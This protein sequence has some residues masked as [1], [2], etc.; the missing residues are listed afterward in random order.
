MLRWND[1]GKRDVN[2]INRRKSN[3]IVDGKIWREDLSKEQRKII[4]KNSTSLRTVGFNKRL[5]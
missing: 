4:Y 2:G 3:K 1:N 5:N